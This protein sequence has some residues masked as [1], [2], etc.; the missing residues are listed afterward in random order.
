[1]DPEGEGQDRRMIKKLNLI[2]LGCAA[3]ALVGLLPP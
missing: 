2:V 1:M 3:L